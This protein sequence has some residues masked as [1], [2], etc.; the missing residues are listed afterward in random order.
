MKQYG[1]LGHKIGYSLS[2]AMHNAAFKHLRLK[3]EYK[4]YDIPDKDVE[5]FLNGLLRSGIGGLN[6]TIPYKIRA[7]Q[8]VK[9][10][11]SMDRETER[12]GSLNT[13][14]IKKRTIYGHNTDVSGFLKALKAD[15]G[16][17]PRMRN[18]FIVGAGGAGQACALRLARMAEKIYIH[19]IDEKKVKAFSEKFLRF[20]G[21]DKLA[22]IQKKEKDIEKALRHS[23]LLVNATAY[24]RHKNE[25]VVN[26]DFLH[27][28]ISVY[29]LIYKPSV[30]PIVKAARERD[31]PAVTGLGMLLYQGA[32]AF[33]LWTGRKAPVRVMKQALE[34]ALGVKQR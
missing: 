22:V 6:V 31:I 33:E 25:M 28:D 3:S 24:G 8:F 26:P 2:P 13:I 9:K 14:V 7:F 1:L 5:V 34:K 19:D 20:Y 30:T 23:H 32:D 12:L 10:Y 11:G 18:I 27:K 21:S 29:D 15:L 16:F 4:I 17:N